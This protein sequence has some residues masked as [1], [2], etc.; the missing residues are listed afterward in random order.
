MKRSLLTGA[1]LLF[2]FS[3][4]AQLTE[5][6]YANAEKFLSYNTQ[7]LVEGGSVRANWLPGD[8][9]W[10][11]SS[12]ANSDTF[13]LVDP[14]KGK[15]VAFDHQKLATALSTFSGKT[16][17]ANKLPF[18]AIN[19]A[20]D[21]KSVSFMLDGKKLKYVHSTAKV[22]EDTTPGT[23]GTIV[24]PPMGGPRG[25][26][27]NGNENLSPDGKKAVFI[28]DWN[29]YV[30]DVATNT[31]KQLTTDGVKDFGYAT[32][33]AAW[34]SSDRA[35]LKWSPDSK[36]ISTFKQDQR[37]L[38]DMH[39]VSTKVG[40][41]ELRSWKYA[42][43]TDKEI[44]KIHRTIID[45]ESGKIVNLQVPADERRGS[46]SDDIASS[47]QFDDNEWSNNSSELLFMSTSRDHK[48]T[49]V[50]IADANTGAVR[51]LFEEV[52]P[53]YYES[54]RG[55][56]NLRY[57][58]ES[59]EVIFYSERDN[60][61]HLYLYDA[62]TGKLK[63]QITKGEWVVTRMLRVDEKARQIYFMT[64]GQD[65]ENPYFQKLNRI[66]FDGKGHVIM[67]P[68]S[69][70]H[71]VAFAP[72]NNMFITTYSK[73][74]VAPV[75]LMKDLTGK[76]IAELDKADISKLEATGW[77]APASVELNAA[78]GKTKVY[79]LVFTPTKMEAGK[80][81]PVVNY[82]YPGPQGG[83]VGGSWGFSAA[84]SDHQALAELGF[85]VVLIEGT[86][87]PFRSKSYH[88]MNYK[89]MAE[90]TLPDQIAGIKQLA[91]TFPID[92]NRVGVWG[93]SGGGFATAS[94][95]FKY[96]DFY[97]VGV[98]Q[99][100]NHDNRNYADSWGDRYNGLA[101]EID[102]VEQA[103]QTHA[104]N[105]K[106]KLL[107][108]HGMMDNN[109]P[110]SHTMLVVD[111]LIKANKDFDLLLFP[112]S[113]HGF[114]QFNPYMMRRRWDYFVKHLQNQDVPKEFPLRGTDN[115]SN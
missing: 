63:N 20:A 115:T 73:P 107:L 103:N 82:I 105:L 52:V 62:A 39:L 88:D 86:S 2:A 36:K 99:A 53:T 51:E 55:A 90:N 79:G 109:V 71:S 101:T 49:K 3:V 64:T 106:G 96:P 37:H 108:A 21:G 100:G 45:L 92:L 102:Y 10:Y 15:S 77:K 24:P 43:P 9:M 59:K 50:R 46:M 110:P 30:R 93:H 8:K 54:G 42:L 66:N 87:N 112:N 4:N 56:I 81:Y 35:V 40:N 18:Q 67:T 95:M 44:A 74:N 104:K 12:N 29:L 32:D 5:K 114:G 69:G 65:P 47:G 91:T 113:A 17:T 41:P 31:V 72:S 111:A 94:A 16:Y 85:I 22:S 25:R 38:S 14:K 48:I 68:E 58:Q 19:V 28:K 11:L 76:T 23:I 83:S 78:D 34:K 1:A 6:D 80:K 89:N 13:Y 84:R 57:L 60:W 75:V 97:K 7:S 98:A 70:T 33:N 27:G 61:G 26:G